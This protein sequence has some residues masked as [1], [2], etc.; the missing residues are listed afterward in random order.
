[1]KSRPPLPTFFWVFLLM[2][3][4]TNAACTSSSS[5][6]PFFET[7]DSAGVRVVL[8]HSPLWGSQPAW[9]I[10][11]TPVLEIGF[12][13]GED[14]Y[15]LN[16]VKGATVSSQGTVVVAN[17]GDCSIRAFDRNGEMVWTSG[18]CGEGPE[19]FERILGIFGAR[20]RL[21]VRQYPQASLRIL[22]TLGTFT[23]TAFPSIPAD[24]RSSDPL[25]VFEDGSVL[26]GDRNRPNV[27]MGPFQVS[28]T[29]GRL[30]A[31]GR[32]DTL[33]TL[34]FL[35]SVRHQSGFGG[36]ERPMKILSLAIHRDRIY[37]S[38]PARY[39]IKILDPEGN[40]E[41]V[42]RRDSKPIAVSE[43]YVQEIR[44]RTMRGEGGVGGPPGF[45]REIVDE[46]VFSE[47]HPAHHGF[48][49]D[50]SGHLWVRVADPRRFD[51]GRT[52]ARIFDEPSSWD[53][54]NPD[55]VWLGIV[56]TPPRFD[57]YEVGE[58]YVL[59][60]WRDELEVEY[61]RKYEL[62]RG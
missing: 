38:W 37:Y 18:R 26:L 11:D 45:L 21:Y 46:M 39:E 25:G 16:R 58:D 31:D 54:F 2:G 53:I 47:F 35:N 28:Y 48:Q 29:V 20:D 13:E 44:D 7:Y 33:T 59:G 61:V 19:E 41:T 51:Y 36:T 50:K 27:D 5:N 12:Q 43:E 42:I 24:F 8:S 56:R 30:Q 15:L 6:T 10:S 60:L 62:I 4:I 52:P 55:G 57:L 49:V 1:L 22:D 17:G 9:A 34:P 23:G 14:P 40:L 3:G 32:I